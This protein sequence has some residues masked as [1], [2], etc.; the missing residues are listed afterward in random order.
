MKNFLNTIALMA[1]TSVV[2]AQG[3]YNKGSVLAIATQTVLTVPDSLVNTG[4]ILNNGDLRI[5]GAWINQGTYDAAGT[6]KINFDS[7]LPQTI[8]HNNQSFNR[9]VISGT[10]DKNFLANITIESELDLQSS[11]L[12]SVN[13]AKIILN[14][15]VTLSGGSD[16]SHVIGPVEI[17]GSGDWLFPIGNGTT[18][19]PVEILGVTDA[20]ASATL[21][22]YETGESLSG[23]IGVSK[24]SGKRYWGLSVNGG[25]ISNSSQIRLPIFDEALLDRLDLLVV[26][27]SDVATSG[28]KSLGQSALVGDLSLGSVTSTDAPT[29]KFY[30]VASGE[31]GIEVFNGI[32][33]NSTEGKNDFFRIKNIELYPDNTV[34]IFNRWGDKI[35]ETKGYDNNQK[36]FSGDSKSSGGKVPAGTYFYSINLG[37]GSKAATG[38]LEIK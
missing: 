34:A 26:A 22:L 17:Q 35:F 20:N 5:S 19:L 32:S 24:L 23:E 11:N 3:F 7:D 4:S 38:Y 18:Y 21:T 28:Y 33:V 25:T 8:N 37:D 13:G 36:K 1:V 27:G 10:G 16:Q 14:P 15:G 30:A 31:T 6:G 12:K 29:L 2:S 9:L